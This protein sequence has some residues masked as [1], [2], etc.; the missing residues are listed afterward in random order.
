MFRAVF[1]I[2]LLAAHVLK[3]PAAPDLRFDIVTFCCQCAPDDSF[4]QPQFDHLN[5]ATTNGHFLAM[6]TDAHRLELATNGNA[7]AAY[8]NTFNDGWPT[9]TGVQ[10]AARV[11][12]YVKAN[13]TSLGPRPDWVVLNEISTSLWTGNAGYRAWVHDVVHALKANFGYSVILYSPF[14]N[15]GANG[16]DWQAVTQDAWI[17]IENYLS[18]AE[19]E[20]HGFSVTW[21]QDQYRSSITSYTN[22]GV[23][24]G[25]LMLGEHFGQTTNVTAWGRSGVASN[26]WDSAILARNQ[27]AQNNAFAGFLSFAWSKNAMLVPDEELIHDEDTYRTNQLP[28]NSGITAPFIVLPP[29]DQVA[30]SGSDVAFIVFKAGTAATTYQW[31]FNGSNLPGA[32]GS[33]LNLANVQ[34]T[35]AGNYSVVLTN[36]AGSMVSSNAFLSVKVPDP[37]AFEPFAPAVTTYAPGANLIGQTNQNGQRW[38]QAGPTS[39]NQPVISSGNLAALGLAGPSGN[40]VRFGGDGTSARFNLGTNS[41]S[42]PWFYSFSVKLVDV[43]GLSSSGIF[44]AGFNN[45]TG[46]QTTTP[47]S[48]GARIVARSAVGGFN[49]GLDKTS[50]SAASFAFAPAVF[51]TNEIIFVV[52]SYTFNAA[53]TN[54]DVAQLWINPAPSSF[55]AATAPP[56]L[57]TNS[58]GNDI[59]QM[60]SLVLFNR[61]TAEPAVIIADEIRVGPSWASV[62]PPAEFTVVPS[63]NISRSG[64][65]TLLSWTTNAPGFVPERAATLADP[66]VWAALNAPVYLSGDQYV[67][68]NLDAAPAFFRLRGSR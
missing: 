59:S 30:P 25:R 40:S 49:L 46:T 52:A 24:R 16:S 2:L 45:S 43:T 48:V 50:G 13:F 38:T 28:V 14:P 64:N 42:G 35:N 7:L 56:S 65:L 27:G 11:D 1:A 36:A 44:W 9:N 55:G 8:Y 68:T 21:C 18:G 26:A 51:T 47:T 15:P 53:T 33:S 61:N 3:A 23:P 34:P 4:C 67:L 32:T 19:V 10:Q 37:A 22:L 57:L 54:D 58:A 20:A 17:G 39:G 62:T 41:S 63:L 6:G 12:Q 5:L 31:R 29:R 66:G 60:A